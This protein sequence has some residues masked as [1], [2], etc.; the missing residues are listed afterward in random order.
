MYANKKK[1]KG[2]GRE[3]GEIYHVG[4]VKGTE[5]LITS[6]RTNELAHALWTEYTH[7]KSFMADRMRLGNTT[8]HYLAV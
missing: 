2:K 1:R 4:N 8:L 3:P 5:N 6:G 7:S